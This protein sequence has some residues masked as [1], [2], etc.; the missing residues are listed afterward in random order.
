[1]REAGV[2]GRGNRL[3]PVGSAIVLEVFA[4]MLTVCDSF[5]NDDEHKDWKPD[6]CIA[7][8][9]HLT[10]ADIVRYVNI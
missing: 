3:G 8:G 5:L 4:S 7:R 10:L 2:I 9:K 1:M 6:A